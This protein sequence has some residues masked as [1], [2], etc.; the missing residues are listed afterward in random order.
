MEKESGKKQL[1]YC[2]KSCGFNEE[3]RLKK[4]FFINN[5]YTD[6]VLMSI[7]KDDYCKIEKNPSCD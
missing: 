2:Y 3:G 4:S 1:H 6:F 7:F 5:T